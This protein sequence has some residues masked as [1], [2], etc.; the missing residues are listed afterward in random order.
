MTMAEREVINRAKAWARARRM[1][2]VIRNANLL[3]GAIE[4]LM[5]EEERARKARK[6]GRGVDE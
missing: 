5:K 4:A 2:D 1:H 3:R 6:E